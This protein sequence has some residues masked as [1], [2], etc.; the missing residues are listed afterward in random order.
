M[1]RVSRWIAMTKTKLLTN[2]LT[3][4]LEGREVVEEAMGVM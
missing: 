4:A 3:L 1:E 2:I